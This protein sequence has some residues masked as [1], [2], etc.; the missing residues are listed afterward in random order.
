MHRIELE[1]LTNGWE[2]KGSFWGQTCNTQIWVGKY[3]LVFTVVWISNGIFH[4]HFGIGSSTTLAFSFNYQNMQYSHK[5]FFNM[6]WIFGLNFQYWHVGWKNRGWILFTQSWKS[7]TLIT[8][9]TLVDVV[10]CIWNDIGFIC[11]FCTLGLSF[12]LL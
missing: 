3:A 8:K 11:K 2:N 10:Y 12:Q 9:Y 5:V 4:M 1:V 6:L 7:Q